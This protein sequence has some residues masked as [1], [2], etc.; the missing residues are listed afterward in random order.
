MRRPAACFQL[1][2]CRDRHSRRNT[3]IHLLV[4]RPMARFADFLELRFPQ[5]PSSCAF[6]AT[7]AAEQTREAAAL[8]RGEAFVR[9][10][11]AGRAGC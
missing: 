5:N 2:R 3:N 10:L 1:Q 11:F 6:F 7:K 8:A 4:L 9:V